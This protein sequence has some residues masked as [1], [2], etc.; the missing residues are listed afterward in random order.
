[1]LANIIKTVLLALAGFGFYL[2]IPMASMPGHSVRILAI[3][4]FVLSALLCF[5]SFMVHAESTKKSRPW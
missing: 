1:M 2:A 3:V 5:L 4:V